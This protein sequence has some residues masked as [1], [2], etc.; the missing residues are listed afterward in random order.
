MINSI[1]YAV[2]MQMRLWRPWV[3]GAEVK[4]RLVFD[5]TIIT[6]VNTSVQ[7]RISYSAP[8]DLFSTSA[9]ASS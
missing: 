9:T 3:G 5:K 7:S 8:D 6:I 4:S 2:K 1:D